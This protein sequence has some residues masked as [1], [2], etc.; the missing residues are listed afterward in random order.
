MSAAVCTVFDPPFENSSNRSEPSLAPTTEPREQACR[1]LPTRL[2]SHEP[3]CPLMRPLAYCYTPVSN[4]S[5]QH[6]P[7]RTILSLYRP[8]TNS[9][10][11]CRKEFCPSTVGLSGDDPQ[12]LALLED[13]HR[14]SEKW[15]RRRDCPGRHGFP[16]WL[17]GGWRNAI[18]GVT[19]PLAAPACLG[20]PG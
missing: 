18:G 16:V 8:A 13:E 17:I 15:S 14:C 6:R 4:C 10:R 3:P 2:F 5:P 1:S 12:P 19:F 7:N 9:A 20:K 11:F